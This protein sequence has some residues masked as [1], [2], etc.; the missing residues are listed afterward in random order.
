MSCDKSSFLPLISVL[1][2][3]QFTVRMS[4]AKKAGSWR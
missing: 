4:T 2:F 3:R 1:L